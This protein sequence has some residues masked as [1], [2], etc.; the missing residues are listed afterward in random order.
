[1][2]DSTRIAKEAA[3]QFHEILSREPGLFDL[4]AIREQGKTAIDGLHK[5][6][7]AMLVESIL[8]IEREELTGV[9]YRPKEAGLQKWGYQQGS[10]FIGFRIFSF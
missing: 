7:G 10:V 9:D 8:Q 5:R 2:K 3:K 6:I 4:L 1:M